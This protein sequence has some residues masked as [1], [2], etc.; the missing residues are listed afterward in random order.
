MANIT[1]EIVIATKKYAKKYPDMTY[2]DIAKLV[3][4]S[5]ASVGNILN[6]MY[7]EDK[8]VESKI[9]YETYRRLVMCEEAVK[10]IFKN[11]KKAIGEDDMM[12]VDYHIVNAIM[13]RCLPEDFEAR[14]N[15]INKD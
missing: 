6:G 9:P 13:N 14:L 3:G 10:E 11:M 2:Q 1:N 4:V 8:A 5:A 12:F 15:E 7:N